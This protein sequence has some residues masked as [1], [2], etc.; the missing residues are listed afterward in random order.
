LA[1]VKL[2]IT[3]R[4]ICSH[5]C[6]V[7]IRIRCAC[8]N[9]IKIVKNLKC[10]NAAGKKKPRPGANPNRG[11][12]KRVITMYT[13]NTA[14]SIPPTQNVAEATVPHLY[15]RRLARLCNLRFGNHVL[16]NDDAGR[17][18]LTALLCF[19]L[20]DESA[21]EDA[22]WCVSELPTFKR[23]ARR[24]KWRDVGTLIGLTFAEWKEAKLWVLR[25]VNAS[26]QDIEDWR[27]DQRKKSWSKSQKK[28]RERDRKQKQAKLATANLERN[29]RQAAILKMLINSGELMS[30]SEL[31][32]KA[33]R[34]H[35]FT[36]ASC[37]NTTWCNGPPAHAIVRNL[38]FVVRRTLDQLEAKGIIETYKI[39]GKH[40]PQRCAR[41]MEQAEI[42]SSTAAS[43]RPAH[44]HIEGLARNVDLPRA[45]V[46]M[47]VSTPLECGHAFGDIEPRPQQEQQRGH[48]R[49]TE[50][51]S[52]FDS[53]RQAA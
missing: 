33:R 22:P 26:E 24:M 3:S 34:S 36:R 13:K 39:S 49:S 31:V 41:L 37:R 25:P 40:G 1:K 10:R 21:I 43:D 44:Q 16:N 45:F 6:R 17:A 51:T 23:Q 48:D 47:G 4:K 2:S 52:I 30:V 9:T 11:N 12:T 29:P 5:I 19:G 20:T 38:P 8:R 27:K 50:V 32:K 7:V 53:N 14:R 35:A 18:M 28:R 46:K 42:G 15:R